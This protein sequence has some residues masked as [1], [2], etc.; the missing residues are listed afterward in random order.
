MLNAALERLRAAEWFRVGE[1]E[2]VEVV[3]RTEESARRLFALQVVQAHQL[4]RRG[5]PGKYGC[6]STAVMLRQI[7]R[8][9]D[10][11][12]RNRVNTALAISPQTQPSG[13]QADPVLPVLAAALAG[14][15][16]GAESANFTVRF[17]NG[18][19]SEL[20]PL[21]RD[22]AE[23]AMVEQAVLGDPS[24]LRKAA[25]QLSIRLDPDGKLPKDKRSRMRLDFGPRNH[26]GMTPITGLL[27][28][29]TVERLRAGGR[30]A[31]RSRRG[32]GRG[33]RSAV[34]VE[35]AGGGV[36]GVGPVVP[37]LRFR[38]VQWWAAAQ[39]HGL[40]GF[41]RSDRTGRPVCEL[42]TQPD[43]PARRPRLHRGGEDRARARFRVG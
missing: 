4:D 40:H 2:L 16:V 27:D 25:Q 5:L 29:E 38:A 28:E 10:G 18:L 21:L 20:S 1:A 33:G 39:R 36:G 35:P 15:T 32:G 14:G 41:G 42:R 30:V 24:Q 19:P 12:A 37:Q 31:G 8:I 7:C 26:W 43:R 3:Q 17:L 23:R 13:A 22:M 6:S 11:E 34:G 9:G